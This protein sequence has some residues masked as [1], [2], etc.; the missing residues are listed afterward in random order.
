MRALQMLLSSVLCFWSVSLFASDNTNEPAQ[1][2][3][4]NH[5]PVRGSIISGLLQNYDNPFVLYPYEPNYIIYTYTSSINKKAI[6][7]YD[8][9][10]DALKDEV[11][12]QLSLA[13]PIWR[14]I[15]GENSVLAASYTQRSWWQLSNKKESSPFR[16]TNYEPQIF[17]GW[18]LDN[19][20]AGWTLREFETGFNHESNGRSDP[21]SRSWNRVYARAMA[22]K[23]DWQVELKP[24]YRIPESESSDDNPD[25]NKYLGYYRVKVG[26]ALGDS[27]IS[28]AG[29]YN[30]NSGY[31]NAELG[32]SYPMTKHVRLYTQLFSGYG[33]SMIDYDYRQTRFG[34]GVMLNDI[35]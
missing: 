20:F 28:A 25:I 6:A 4:E 29:H 35:M 33:E 13:F 7:S 34:I 17:V 24:W 9:G 21:T 30:W 27:V 31:G 19:Q 12:F 14:G 22:Q 5:T 18:A 15:A 10:N 11:K 16:E 23:G 26:Y 1:Q 8:W 2:D 3:T 32:W